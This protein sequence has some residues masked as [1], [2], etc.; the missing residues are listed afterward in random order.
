MTS[1]ASIPVDLVIAI[2][3]STSMKEEAVG[4]SQAAEA[5]IEAARS[6]CPSDLRVV[7]LGLEGTWKESNFDRTVRD[8]LT[9]ECKVKEADIRGRKRS[10]VKSGGAQEDGARTIEDLSTHFDWRPDATR[11]ILYLSDEGLEGGGSRVNKKDIDAA[12]RAIE[13]AKKAQVAVHTYFGKSKSSHKKAIQAEYARVSE[14]TKGRAFTAADALEGFTDLL[15]TVI[16]ATKE[17]GQ[18]V[19]E[20]TPRPKPAPEKPKPDQAISLVDLIILIESTANMQGLASDIGQAGEAAIQ[21]FQTEHGRKPTILWVTSGTSW[22]NTY[23]SQ[24]LHQ[25]LVDGCGVASS[26]LQSDSWAIEEIINHVQWSTKE[27]RGIFYFGDGALAQGNNGAIFQNQQSIQQVIQACS[28]AGITVYSHF[29]S[30]ETATESALTESSLYQAYSSLTQATGGALYQSSQEANLQSIFTSVISSTFNLTETVEVEAELVVSED[31]PMDATPEPQTRPAMVSRA[32]APTDPAPDVEVEAELVASEDSPMDATPEPQTRPATV[33]LADAPTDPAPDVEAQTE[34]VVSEDSPMDATPEPQT[35]P[36]MVS[37]TESSTDSAPVVSEDSPFETAPTI[38]TRPAAVAFEN[39]LADMAQQVEQLMNQYTTLSTSSYSSTT[40]SHVFSQGSLHSPQELGSMDLEQLS[41]LYP[42]TQMIL[43]QL[44]MEMETLQGNISET[45]K[46]TSAQSET[47]QEMAIEGQ[48]A[49]RTWLAAME[50][51]FLQRE[52][53]QTSVNHI[54]SQVGSTLSRAQAANKIFLAER[55][56]LW[57]QLIA[58]NSSGVQESVTV[59]REAKEAALV[60][61]ERLRGHIAE[62]QKAL[63]MSQQERERIDINIR[64]WQTLHQKN[65]GEMHTLWSEIERLKQQIQVSMVDYETRQKRWQARDQQQQNTIAGHQETLLSEQQRRRQ[66]EDEIAQLRVRLGSTEEELRTAQLQIQTVTTQY[67]ERS[68]GMEVVQNAWRALLAQMEEL[69]RV[70]SERE[71]VVTARSAWE[72]RFSVAL[73][74]VAAQLGQLEQLPL[75]TVHEVHQVSQVTEQSQ[76]FSSSSSTST[77]AASSS[78]TESS[79]A[80][81]SASVLATPVSG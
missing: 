41:Q 47:I 4:L 75:T 40:L 26:A 64:E 71:S 18:S 25:Y 32:D 30:S 6:S 53:I 74:E 48:N 45:A 59:E 56:S 36:A 65:Q 72:G 37:F 1:S 81:T 16:C 24:S 9:K 38:Q 12:N 8:Y 62:L 69:N 55:D 80:A 50:S 76:S 70:A 34:L 22:T 17:V 7:W 42:E 13:K 35:R 51:T 68:T 67:E 43:A 5:A 28:M 46:N 79:S 33:T 44:E 77:S 11:A 52:E 57:N 58:L 63:A 29:S 60:E 3:T 2:D 49:L 21:Q 27:Y 78:A 31:S 61:I 66:A 23:F 20:S 73:S 19:V 39:P 14:G 15:E 54:L 10:Q